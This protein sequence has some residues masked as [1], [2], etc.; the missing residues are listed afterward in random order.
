YVLFTGNMQEDGDP[1]K[2]GAPMALMRI[3][4]GPIIGGAGGEVRTVHPEAAHGPVLTLPD[5]WEPCW[6][7]ADVVAAKQA[8]ARTA[9]DEGA[10]ELATEVRTKGWIAF[11][12]KGDQDWDLWMMRPNGSDRHRLTDTREFHEAG[13]RFSPD[14]GQMP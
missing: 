13:V 2:A 11:S 3:K 1:G 6:T 7:P 9:G 8:D 12:A 10:A 14:G 5:G 4:D